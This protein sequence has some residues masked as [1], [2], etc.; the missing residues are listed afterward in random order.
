MV[1]VDTGGDFLPELAR[2]I[3]PKNIMPVMTSAALSVCIA[4]SSLP[5]IS[6]TI[7]IIMSNNPM[8]RLPF[9]CCDIELTF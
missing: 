7:G 2:R 9:D 1:G 5:N 6:A 8:H 3:I 4:G